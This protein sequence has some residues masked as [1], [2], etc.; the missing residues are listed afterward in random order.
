MPYGVFGP[1]NGWQREKFVALGCGVH[2]IQAQ[3]QVTA[4]TSCNSPGVMQGQ[5]WYIHRQNRTTIII[6]PCN[7]YSKTTTAERLCTS[8]SKTTN[9][10][11]CIKIN[12]NSYQCILKILNL[13]TEIHLVISYPWLWN[14]YSNTSRDRKLDF[15]SSAS[16]ALQSQLHGVPAGLTD[17]AGWW[18]PLTL[19]Q[20]DQ[21][22]CPY[23]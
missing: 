9:L 8:P 15:S 22:H 16:Q 2:D 19:I 14:I 1:R 17:G 12:M 23:S 20:W 18:T 7:F 6:L 11:S 5:T 10:T 21:W 4:E 13:H 3:L